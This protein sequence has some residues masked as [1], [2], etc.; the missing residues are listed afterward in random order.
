LQQCYYSHYFISEFRDNETRI[1]PT[2][3]S[4]DTMLIKYVLMKLYHTVILQSLTL[5]MLKLDKKKMQN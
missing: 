1:V 2:L 3:Y 5:E 4:C